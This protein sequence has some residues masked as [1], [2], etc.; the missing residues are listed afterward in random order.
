MWDLALVPCPFPSRLFCRELQAIL[1]RSSYGVLVVYVVQLT[2]LNGK[3]SHLLPRA[4]AY[5]NRIAGRRFTYP[6]HS[7]KLSSPTW[8]REWA[9]VLDFGRLSWP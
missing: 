1:E 9:S 2:G 8:P 3:S 5:P 7:S 6:I 4:K